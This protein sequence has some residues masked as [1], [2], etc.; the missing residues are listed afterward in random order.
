LKKVLPQIRIIH[1][2]KPT[3]DVDLIAEADYV[4]FHAGYANHR[5]FRTA[6]DYARQAG[7]RICYVSHVNVGLFLQEICE[8][9]QAT[10]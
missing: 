7:K 4:V 5:Q 1:P 2:D 9:L 6:I 3:V 10:Y 8:D